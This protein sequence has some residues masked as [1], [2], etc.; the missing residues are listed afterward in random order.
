MN[1]TVAPS[2]SR[3]WCSKASGSQC[4]APAVA[5]VAHDSTELSSPESSRTTARNPALHPLGRTVPLCRDKARVC[6]RLPPRTGS[7]C[8]GAHGCDA[9]ATS[10][11]TNNL[12][13]AG[14]GGSGS[15]ATANRPRNYSR[16]GRTAIA[17]WSALVGLPLGQGI[18]TAAALWIG[19][20][21]SAS[22]SKS[23]STRAVR[24]DAGSCCGRAAA[25]PELAAAKPLLR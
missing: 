12:T 6:A 21:D 19:A 9:R 15:L 2:S 16:P 18:P 7:E 4:R 13:R 5:I 10:R 17:R 24:H 25:A 3:W 20:G 11:R 1:S 14:D 8:D 22:A 23:W